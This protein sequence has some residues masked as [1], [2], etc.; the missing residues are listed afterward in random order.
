MDSHGKLYRMPTNYLDPCR[1]PC[2][3]TAV[4]QS[5]VEFMGIFKTKKVLFKV[6]AFMHTCTSSDT[7]KQKLRVTF[8]LINISSVF[9]PSDDGQN[10][11]MAY[12]SYCA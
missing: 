2:W 12:K 9:A 7:L 6:W 3:S 8:S 5:L 4:G 1:Q 11:I 10:K